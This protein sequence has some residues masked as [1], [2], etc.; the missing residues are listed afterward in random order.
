MLRADGTLFRSVLAGGPRGYANIAPPGGGGAAAPAVL[1]SGTLFHKHRT[2]WGAASGQPCKDV[3]IHVRVWPTGR[4][5]R[6]D[7]AGRR[8]VGV[9]HAPCAALGLAT[10]AGRMRATGGQTPTFD[11]PRCTHTRHTREGCLPSAGLKGGCVARTSPC[12][13]GGAAASVSGGPRRGH[14]ARP[15]QA[16]AACSPCHCRSAHALTPT[17]LQTMRPSG[18]FRAQTSLL[19][20]G[21]PVSGGRWQTHLESRHPGR[22]RSML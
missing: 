8:K 17:R 4:A 14:E 5:A 11:R 12:H 20:G 15:N 7:A 3:A 19:G 1:H 13:H 10:P 6:I 18:L 21:A 16:G 2:V 22:A 9:R